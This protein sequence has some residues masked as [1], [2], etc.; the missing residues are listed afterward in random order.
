MSR[1]NFIPIADMLFSPTVHQQ[2]YLVFQP[3]WHVTVFVVTPP[4]IRKSN[5]FLHRL[6]WHCGECNFDLCYG[7]TK[8]HKTTAHRHKLQK[9]DPQNI[10]PFM[11][12]WGCDLC[13][14]IFHQSNV[15]KP[16]HCVSNCEF[17][18]CG[19]CMEGK[20]HSVLF[21]YEIIDIHKVLLRFP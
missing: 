21:C 19:S 9:V 16:Y 11:D 3:V 18:L 8:N 5:F 1:Q 13:K 6:S 4:S 2:C 7:C 12:S 17:D 20:K 15:E 14:E 10:Y